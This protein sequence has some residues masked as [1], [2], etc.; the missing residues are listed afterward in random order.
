ME[1]SIIRATFGKVGTKPNG[2]DYTGVDEWMAAHTLTMK[3]GCSVAYKL[4]TLDCCPFQGAP[5]QVKLLAWIEGVQD[6]IL[7]R[8]YS[9]NERETFTSWL[10]LKKC[11]TQNTEP[12]ISVTESYRTPE[13]A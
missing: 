6:I 10:E 4:A 2:E 11:N 7:S 13:P 8:A 9:N 5:D 3:A 12:I 1:K